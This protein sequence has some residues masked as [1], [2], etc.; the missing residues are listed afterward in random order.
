MNKDD[1]S[2][3]G[4]SL[5]VHVHVHVRVC[6]RLFG[7]DNVCVDQ[8]ELVADPEGYAKYIARSLKIHCTQN[9]TSVQISG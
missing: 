9:F 3:C 5:R 2:S 8:L 4:H 7:S 1:G 6:I